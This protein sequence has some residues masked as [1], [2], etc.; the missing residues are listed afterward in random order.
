V[1]LRSLPKWIFVYPFQPFFLCAQ[2]DRCRLRKSADA[3]VRGGKMARRVNCVQ[4]VVA[5]A[6]NQHTAEDYCRQCGRST[7]ME[8]VAAVDRDVLV[9][10]VTETLYERCNSQFPQGGRTAATATFKSVPIDLVA[11]FCDAEP[12]LLRRMNVKSSP[13]KR[14]VKYVTTAPAGGAAAAAPEGG[15]LIDPSTSPHLPVVGVGNPV[16]VPCLAF[17]TIDFCAIPAPR[18]PARPVRYVFSRSDTTEYSP[19]SRGWGLYYT[20]V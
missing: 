14:R 8:G 13:S 20:S 19:T 17:E 9:S 3:A 11:A 18:S 10:A 12:G 5:T 15:A 1:Y 4:C 2:I 16:A 7:D 6:S